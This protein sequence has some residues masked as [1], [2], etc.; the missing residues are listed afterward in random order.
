[1]DFE[2]LNSFGINLDLAL[3]AQ[4]IVRGQTGREIPG[5]RVEREKYE[6]ATV[7]VVHIE[8]EYAEP[9]VGKPK[10]KYITVEAPVMRENS[11]QGHRS[12]AEVLGAQLNKLLSLPMTANV[13]VVGL[14]NWNATPDSLGPRVIRMIPV[15]R[16]LFAYAP[17]ELKGGM[18]PVSALAPGVLGITGIETAEIIK[19]VVEK[20]RPEVVIAIDSLASRSVARIATTVQIADTG[21]NPGSGIGNQRTAINKE[22]IGVPVIAIGVPTV[23]HAAVIAS[24]AIQEFIRQ[25]PNTTANNETIKGAIESVL[26]PFGGNL[27]VTPRE[28]DTLIDDAAKIIA[29]GIAMSLHPGISPDDYAYYLH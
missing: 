6:Y 12:V 5:V 17:Q 24:D 15:T 3:E 1:M 18:R 25:N 4:E 22:S 28:I 7:T 8:E 14:G 13:L 19:G 26:E 27:T 16:H 21:I 29:G 2:F 9:I 23:V 20:I 11:P 10:G